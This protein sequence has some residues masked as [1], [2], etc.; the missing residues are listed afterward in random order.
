MAT[1]KK[2]GVLGA[3]GYTGSET[4]R[5]LLRHPKVEIAALTADRSA[6]K[7]MRDVFR[8]SCRSR[9]RNSCRSIN[10][11]GARKNSI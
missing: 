11:T 7:E 1:L 9:C 5:L 4:V 3:S 10:S 2:V 8:S 6:G